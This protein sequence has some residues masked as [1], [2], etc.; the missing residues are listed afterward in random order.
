ME[1]ID[2]DAIKGECT[3]RK[4]DKLSLAEHYIS[5][6]QLYN[7][8]LAEH[9]KA[10]DMIVAL[11]LIISEN[12]KDALMKCEE[13][14]EAKR[15]ADAERKNLK[16]RLADAKKKD[17]KQKEAEAE[18]KK[19]KDFGALFSQVEALKRKDEERDKRDE[20]RD[21]R[22]EGRDKRDEERDKRDEERD[23][24]ISILELDAIGNLLVRLVN[25]STQII[26]FIAGMQPKQNEGESDLF[27]GQDYVDRPRETKIKNFKAKA[28][29]LRTR[30]NNEAHPNSIFELNNA[31]IAVRDSIELHYP[32]LIKTLREDDDLKFAYLVVNKW[33]ENLKNLAEN[34]MMK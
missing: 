30:R 23:K 17:V 26:L 27:S 24:K 10:K 20:E 12:A 21:K 3:E 25:I 11:Q 14:E 9:L 6:G 1:P 31:V 34:Y 22:D 8:L 28:D 33:E 18:S 15:K 7:E 29:K 16:P 2:I 5:L 13:S 19:F 4:H 32:S